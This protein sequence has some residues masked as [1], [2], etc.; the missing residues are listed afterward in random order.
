METGLIWTVALVTVIS[1]VICGILAIA[2]HGVAERWAIIG[3]IASIAGIVVAVATAVGQHTAGT[4]SNNASSDHSSSPPS[5][6]PP[7]P[8]VTSLPATSPLRTRIL[9]MDEVCSNLGLSQHAWLPGQDSATNIS[10]RAILES[11]AAYAWSCTRSGPRLTRDDITHGCQI[12]YPGATAYTL[13]P[14]DAYS[15]VCI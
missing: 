5:A 10:G 13:D 12:W 3:V 4:N 7:S 2:L 1:F 14:D 8:G 15:W 11:G 6:P 9:D